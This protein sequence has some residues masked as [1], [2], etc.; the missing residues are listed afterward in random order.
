[1]KTTRWRRAAAAVV[2]I[3]MAGIALAAMNSPAAAAKQPMAR[4]TLYNAAGEKVGEVVFKGPGKY[5]D[6]RVVPRLPHPHDRCV[7]P[8][9]VWVDQRAVRFGGWALEPHRS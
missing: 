9:A 4:A 7:Q 1:M 8:A 2:A 3:A 5:A 6:P